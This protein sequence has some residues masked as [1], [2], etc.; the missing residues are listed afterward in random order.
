VL[1]IE[2]KTTEGVEF[3]ILEGE[4]DMYVAPQ[5]RGTLLNASEVCE[6]AVAID[7]NNVSYMDSSGIAT[8]IEGLQVTKRRGAR[9]VLVGVQPN[10]MDMLRLAKLHDFFEVY[11]TEREALENLC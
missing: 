4:I 3:I 5:I 1:N 6:K 10:V 9:L 11:Q 2:I 8:L 7:L